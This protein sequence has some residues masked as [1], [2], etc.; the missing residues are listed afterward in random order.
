MRRID[1]TINVTIEKRKTF[2]IAFANIETLQ[3]A[4]R[5]TPCPLTLVLSTYS[6][7]RTLCIR[8]CVRERYA[9]TSCTVLSPFRWYDIRIYNGETPYSQRHIT[10]KQ[11]PDVFP[12]I[13]W[14]R[15]CTTTQMD[16]RNVTSAVLSLPFHVDRIVAL[17]DPLI[18]DW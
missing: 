6:S 12:S 1:L 5:L 13:W 10:E 4:D 16:E 17:R 2:D 7:S 14:Y 15:A 18:R 8:A 11:S 9:R 3:H